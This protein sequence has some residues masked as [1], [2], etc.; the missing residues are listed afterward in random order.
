MSTTIILDDVSFT[1][2]TQQNPLFE[3][4]DLSF[5][6]GWTALSGAN[7]SGKTTLAMLLSGKL[8]PD[9]GRIRVS[10]EVYYCPQLFT[11]IDVDDYQYLYDYSA[12]GME[13]RRLLDLDDDMLSRPETLS[14]GER[15]RLQIFI[16]LSR[17]P[18]LLILDEPTNHL[19]EY[20]R[21]LLL[22][23]LRRFDGVGV[24]ISHDRA[25]CDA[26]V[27]RTLIF[28][29]P[30][31][32]MPVHVEDMPLPV[33]K[34]FA[35]REGRRNALLSQRAAL[36]GRLSSLDQT[37]RLLDQKVR[38]GAQKLSKRNLSP[39]DH[40]GAGRIDLA[41]VSGKDRK[42]AD[43]KRA[44][45]SQIDRVRSDL[46]KMED[47]RLRK[48]GL[49]SRRFNTL[50]SSL[51]VP[52]GSIEVPGY[53]LDFPSFEIP[54]MSRTA[55]CGVNGAGK[56]LLVDHLISLARA[57]W[58]D[59]LVAYIPQEY[60]DDDLERVRDAFLAMD[61]IQRGRIAS[62]LYRMEGDPYSFM[63]EGLL[64][65]PGELR[66]LD[67]LLALDRTPAL[68]VM[69]EPT[70]HLDITS[71]M[72]LESMLS[73]SSLTLVLV[74]HDAAFRQAL[75]TRTLAVVREGECGHVVLQ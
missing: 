19:D 66:K 21:G 4:L 17:M 75:C 50:H 57:K 55:I 15:K 43:R 6:E 41:R 38:Q 59:D 48:S 64:L 23:A 49:S 37:H 47:V 31:S 42:D 7:G 45:E 16:A 60:G 56:S 51:P 14:G 25:F 26:L 8:F 61:D 70:N 53:R 30:D 40:D 44:L 63:E 62:D 34:A 68:L 71:V 33:T 52:A 18:S 58:G 10:G 2:P 22:D 54:P 28:S 24:V 20:N 72:A 65:S 12:Y 46:S 39:K 9:A 13:L 67:I 29:R 36:A 35:E 27:K 69:D 73:S 5:H 11:T 1:Y 32:T 3:H 74:S